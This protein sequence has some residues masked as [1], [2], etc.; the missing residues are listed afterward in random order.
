MK[1]FG[2]AVE[3]VE[4]D[5][6]RSDEVF[7]AIVDANIIID[8]VHTTVPGSSMNDPAYDIVSNVVSTVSWLRRLPQTKVT[9]IIYFS[10]GGTV[11]G[12]P[13]TIPIDENH[14]TNPI[15]SYGITKLAIEKYIM[16]Y[17]SIAEIDYCLLRPSNV[18]GPGQRLHSG[19]GLVGIMVERVLRGEPLEVWGTGKVQRDYLYVDDLVDATMALMTAASRHKVFNVSSGKSY[20]VLEIITMIGNQ[21]GF[22]PEISFRPARDF[23]V[24]ISLL[25][26]SRLMTETGWRPKV[27]L[28]T[29]ITRTIEWLK[30]IRASTVS[31]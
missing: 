11:Y 9:K 8:L 21:L 10:S 2:N 18:Y 4:G 14:P 29:G 15:S 7:S 5:F 26:S 1:D 6:A 31:I 17:C 16:M 13:Q 28:E 19:Q 25:D 22:T 24:P 12:V 20:S 30:S 3:V 23:D 27:A